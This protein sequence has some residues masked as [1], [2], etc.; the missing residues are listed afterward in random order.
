MRTRGAGDRELAVCRTRTT[1]MRGSL[2]YAALTPQRSRLRIRTHQSRRLPASR[3][4]IRLVRG[5]QP[6][7]YGRPP[8]PAPP[9]RWSASADKARQPYGVRAGDELSDRLS[10][11]VLLA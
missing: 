8:P 2:T 6:T 7:G 3:R 5:P 11:F 10:A 9:T 1:A 4:R